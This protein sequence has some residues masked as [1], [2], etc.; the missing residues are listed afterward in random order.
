MDSR[1]ETANTGDTSSD[2]TVFASGGVFRG[3]F[4]TEGDVRIVGDFEGNISC[5][6]LMIELDGNVDGNVDAD[7]VSS[8]G[9][10]VGDVTANNIFVTA[11][12]T[13]EGNFMAIK[14]GLEPGAKI[15]QANLDSPEEDA[16]QNAGPSVR[17]H[18]R[19]MKT[20]SAE[21]KPTPAE[22]REAAGYTP[23][24][25]APG[26]DLSHATSD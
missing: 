9:R 2:V 18:P 8:S 20:H 3:D 1:N 6:K 15:R 14:Y 11:S 13:L 10:L 16:V 24:P 4:E 21:Q 12:A 23:R 19:I 22:Q 7:T 26:R 25:S 17:R 5:N